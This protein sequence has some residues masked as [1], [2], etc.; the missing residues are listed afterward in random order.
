MDEVREAVEWLKS[1]ECNVGP[2]SEK[3]ISVVLEALEQLA[4]ARHSLPRALDYLAT[5][6]FAVTKEWCRGWDAARQHLIE[7]GQ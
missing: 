1:G 5:K 2:R 4:Q 3:A 7:G 6:Q